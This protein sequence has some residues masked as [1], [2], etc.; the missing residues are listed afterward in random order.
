MKFVQKIKECRAW[1]IMVDTTPDIT[2]IEQVSICIRIV[3]NSE[4][5][6]EHLIGCQ[7]ATST[8]AAALYGVIEQAFKLKSVPLDKL[9]TQTY[10]GASNMSGCYNGL[11]AIVKEKIGK[12]IIY[13]HCYAHSLDLVL[14]DVASD[15]INV[16]SLFSNLESLHNLFN[17][18]HKVH[19][20]FEKVQQDAN[21]KV[22]STKRLNTVRWSSRETCLKVF[23]SRYD[24]IMQVLQEIQNDPSFQDNKRA[25]ANGLINPS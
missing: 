1:S 23:C 18:S 9:A 3:A 5:S 20:L 13:V 15:N 19:V 17:T 25:C 11:Q 22:L 2:D 7:E 16:L 8:T 10:D 6:S 21:L 14:S 12:H 24:P 4:K